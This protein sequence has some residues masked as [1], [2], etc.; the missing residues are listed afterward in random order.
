MAATLPASLPSLKPRR[1][2][3]PPA[4]PPERRRVAPWA[5]ALFRWLAHGAAWLTLALLVGIIVSLVIGALPAIQEFGLGF[6]WRTE[7]DPVQRSSA[8]W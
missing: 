7:W 8:A 3:H 1:E 6:L 2:P 5:D 4:G